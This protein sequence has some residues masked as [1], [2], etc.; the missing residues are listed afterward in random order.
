MN[1]AEVEK[2]AHAHGLIVMGTQHPRLSGAKGLD[3]GTL[4][5]LGAAGAFWPALK[6]SPEWRDGEEA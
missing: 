3:G 6:A 1:Y 5:L 4:I 2:A